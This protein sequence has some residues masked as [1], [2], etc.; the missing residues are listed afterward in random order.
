VIFVARGLTFHEP[1][2]EDNE[3]LAVRKL[4][5][6]ELFG[7]VMRGE[8]RDCLTVAAVMKVN[9]LLMNGELAP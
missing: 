9:L 8:V 4:A 3:E 2:P 5:F 7:M 6:S 1:E